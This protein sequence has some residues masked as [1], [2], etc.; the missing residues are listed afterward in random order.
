MNEEQLNELLYQAFETEL[1]GVNV[2]EAA[3]RCVRNDDLRQEWEKYH[4]QTTHHVEVVRGLLD[5]FGL[6]PEVETPG[7]TVVRHIGDS[8]VK[9]MEMALSEGSGEAA[10]LVAAE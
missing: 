1:G 5:E 4:D 8:L 6:D 9:A 3:L 7:R 2:Y 10:E